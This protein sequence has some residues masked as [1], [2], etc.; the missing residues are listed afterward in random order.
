MSS[1]YNHQCNSKCSTKICKTL[2]LGFMSWQISSV[3]S[4]CLYW[5]SWSHLSRVSQLLSWCTFSLLHTWKLLR[6]S[7]WAALSA[8]FS[9]ERTVEQ[10]RPFKRKICLMIKKLWLGWNYSW[11]ATW[12][13][14]QRWPYVLGSPLWGYWGA[15]DDWKCCVSRYSGSQAITPSSNGHKNNRFKFSCIEKMEFRMLFILTRSCL[16]H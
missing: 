16:K 8:A 15:I 9:L 4:P 6:A 3:V 11:S 10:E 14:S 12:R 7:M 1:L 2:L 13:K 5:S